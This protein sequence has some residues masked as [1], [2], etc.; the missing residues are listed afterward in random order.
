[1][2]MRNGDAKGKS[3]GKGKEV[4]HAHPPQ[5]HRSVSGHRITQQIGDLGTVHRSLMGGRTAAATTLNSTVRRSM[6]N[7][8]H[9]IPPPQNPPTSSTT[10]PPKPPQQ[11][12]KP[13]AGPGPSTRANGTN[14]MKSP[15]S[16]GSGRRQSSQSRT[17][18]GAS[19]R[20][21]GNPTGL[22]AGAPS[23]SAKHKIEMVDDSESST[24]EDDWDTED[25][26]DD[27]EGATDDGQPQEGEGQLAEAAAE[28]QRHRDMFAK[29]DRRSYTQLNRSQSGLLSQIFHPPP[30]RFPIDH[31]YRYSR[32]T[33]DIL[34][35][36][37]QGPARQ[38][39]MPGAMTAMQ[40]QPK[41]SV[42]MPTQ[43]NV[44]A[45]GVGSPNHTRKSP[46][47]KPPQDAEMESDSGDD[48]EN[49]LDMSKSLAQKK[50]QE[51]MTRS[52]SK[53]QQQ[54][55]QAQQSQIGQQ[56]PPNMQRQLPPAQELPRSNTYAN[57]Q[58]TEHHH[59]PANLPTVATAPIDLGYPYNLPAPM[60]P[61]TPRAARRHF[62]TNELS[63][64]LRRNIL[65]E[66]QVS[67][68]PLGTRRP[69]TAAGGIR[70]L[71]GV[72]GQN[73]NA[74]QT[75]GRPQVDEQTQEERQR[76]RVLARNKSY[77]EDF[78]GAGW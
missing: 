33:Q 71:T 12:E 34:A 3:K 13:V 78:H 65:W 50:L 22:K 8:S 44:V 68:R 26:S 2:R 62:L 43:V 17:R 72:N 63:E 36:V 15:V 70:P 77:Q 4:G 75:N 10:K 32:S 7:H 42:A 20:L 58:Q 31:P 49:K 28:A 57:P 23:T 74:A 60:P 52:S 37:T 21:V 6:N 19:S 16:S 25:A 38:F 40:A 27:G 30:D 61:F 29:V 41:S 64:S 48:T 24:D 5:V 18:S 56:R 35:H 66:R 76:A 69:A 39:Y 73:G 14:G 67:K 11:M 45:Q 54:Q 59:I 47:R 9:I 51:H 1:M 46:L 55:Q 53:Q